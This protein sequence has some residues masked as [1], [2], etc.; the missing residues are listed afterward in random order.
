MPSMT[1]AVGAAPRRMSAVFMQTTKDCPLQVC[2]L[3]VAV[4]AG[5]GCSVFSLCMCL[6]ITHTQMQAYGS[7]LLSNIHDLRKDMCSKEF[8]ALKQCF[9]RAVR[10]VVVACTVQHT[11]ALVDLAHERCLNHCQAQHAASKRR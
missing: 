4:V 9:Q 6:P 1:R 7:C 5:V 10:G 8:A 3:C 11:P 2:A